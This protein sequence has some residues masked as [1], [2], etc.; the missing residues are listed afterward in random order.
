M[1][2]KLGRWKWERKER[3]EAGMKKGR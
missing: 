3:R 1:S 2:P